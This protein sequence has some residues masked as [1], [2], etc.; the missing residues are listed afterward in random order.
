MH[1]SVAVVHQAYICACRLFICVIRSCFSVFTIYAH[2]D[3]REAHIKFKTNTEHWLC[4]R[5]PEMF[6]MR[7]YLR[8]NH[9]IRKHSVR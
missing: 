9:L 3:V 6:M 8:R 1:E 7:V 2:K 5:M 4:M